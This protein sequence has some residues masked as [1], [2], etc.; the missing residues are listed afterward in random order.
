MPSLT[1]DEARPARPRRRRLLRVELDLDRGPTTFEST[2]T[3]R[4]PCRDVGA[5]TWLDVARVVLHE[6]RLNGRA[7]DVGGPDRRPV[8]A[9]GPRRGQRGRGRARRWPTAATARACTAPSTRP[10]ARPTS[11]ATR[12]L[13]AAPRMF[14]LLRPARPQGALHGLGDG[15]AALDRRRQ[16]RGDAYAAPGRWE[17]ASHPAARDLLRHG[18]RRP[19]RHPPRRARRHPARRSTRG[20]RWR[21]RSTAGPTRSSPSPGRASTGTTACSASGTRSASTTRCSSRSS[22]PAP[23]RTPAA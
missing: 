22:T 2:S 9:P 1:R 7:L 16:R 14:A 8:R 15:P 4:F 3:I 20:A 12:F 21:V 13:A 23:W 18:L 11:T 5:S 17:L 10:T 6:V 19:L